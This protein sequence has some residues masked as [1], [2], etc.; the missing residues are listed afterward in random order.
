MFNDGTFHV[1]PSLRNMKYLDNVLKLDEEWILLSN[2]HIGNL[3]ETVLRCHKA[4][5]KV[6]VNHEIV[7]GLGAD[8]RAFKLLKQ[9]YE[10]DGVMG[11]SS[12]KLAV[13]KKEGL[14]T[15]RRIPLIDSL[16]IEQTFNGL[17]E[18]KCDVL[19][20][21]P[22]YYALKY[23][24]KF[25]KLC[26]CCYVAGGFVEDKEMVDELYKAGFSAVMTSCTRLWG[27]KP[28]K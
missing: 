14:Q 6:L 7:G 4:G 28:G 21:R 20:L 11:S 10:V 27:Y 26:P 19:E 23:L 12:S 15:I 5:K 18:V 24:D 17:Q 25:Q 13:L 9:L 8:R 16:A 3:K 1:I 22:G 2:I